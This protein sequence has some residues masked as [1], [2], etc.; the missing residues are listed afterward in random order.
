MDNVKRR[1]KQ[2]EEELVEAKEQCLFAFERSKAMEREVGRKHV[3]TLL[4]DYV[5]RFH[6]K[7]LA[8][9][10]LQR[11]NIQFN[12]DTGAHGPVD[13]REGGTKPC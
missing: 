8:V 5:A 11:Y 12:T 2:A 10:Y 9:C 6:H 1:L 7:A 4:H 13:T 3:V